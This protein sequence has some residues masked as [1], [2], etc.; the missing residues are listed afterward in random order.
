[1]LKKFE[2]LFLLLYDSDSRRLTS[3]VGAPR[4]PGTGT[5][6]GKPKGPNLRTSEKKL[7][8]PKADEQKLGIL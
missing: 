6:G 7:Q 5:G 4:P 2:F 3:E 1:M 8:R